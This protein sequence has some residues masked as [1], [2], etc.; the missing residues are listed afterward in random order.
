MDDSFLDD[1]GWAVMVAGVGLCLGR[2]FYRGSL[3]LF[4]GA[5]RRNISYFV[6]RRGESFLWDMGFSVAGL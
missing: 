3:H 5:D 1:R 2:I 4:N 6:S